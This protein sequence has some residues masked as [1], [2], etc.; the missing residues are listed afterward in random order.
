MT[1]YIT[2]LFLLLLAL[3]GKLAANTK[4]QDVG[5]PIVGLS[6]ST[7]TAAVVALSICTISAFIVMILLRHSRQIQDQFVDE[8]SKK[9]RDAVLTYPCLLTTRSMASVAVAAGPGLL[10][11][12]ALLVAFF[13]NHG[14]TKAAVSSAFFALPYLILAR[15][16]WA[17][18]RKVT[19][20]RD[21]R[22]A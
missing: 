5:I 14:F 7:F 12:V 13:T 1:G 8:E 4:E 6:A 15:L 11:A 18:P 22:A 20:L 16:V 19:Q 9:L 10:L 3:G 17:A 2:A 21:D